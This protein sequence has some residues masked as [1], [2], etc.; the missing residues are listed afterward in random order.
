MADRTR[1]HSN[2][3]R[4]PRNRGMSLDD[5]L[6]HQETN[7]FSRKSQNVPSRPQFRSNLES[8]MYAKVDSDYSNEGISSADDI[9][10]DECE[11]ESDGGR[12][13]SHRHRLVEQRRR[14]LL[15][16]QSSHRRNQISSGL[17]EEDAVGMSAKEQE[18]LVTIQ[19]VQR[20]LSMI[21]VQ[22]EKSQ[23]EMVPS[24]KDSRR[25]LIMV[26]NRLPIS[27]TRDEV[28]GEWTFTM[29]SGGLVTA[30]NGIRDEVPFI[31][32]GWLGE[33][34]AQED[35]EQVREKL[36]NE[37]N[38]VPVFLPKELAARYYNDFSNDIL[39]PIFHYVP[40]PMFRPG[41]EKKF[42]FRPWEAYKLANKRFAQ[43]VHQ[44]YREGDFVWVHDYHLMM[45]PS[46]LRKRHPKATIAWFLHTPFPASDVYRMLP[47]GQ[48]ILR[49]LLGADLLGFHTY[50]YARHFLS[51]C[52]RIDGPCSTPKG[53]ELQDHFTAVGVYPIGIDPDHFQKLVD[54]EMTQQR[55]K[56]LCSR[57]AG[58]K[59]IIGVDRMDY[60]K[61]IPH[62]ML[63]M[64][65]FLTMYPK[66]RENVVLIQ[67]AVP[68]RTSVLEY[69]NLAANVNEMVGRINGRFSTIEHSPVH[70]I[71]RS[72]RPHELVA[73]YNVAD[74]CLVT[75]LRDGMNLVSHEYVM[76]QVRECSARREGPG[77]LVLSEFAGSAQSLSGAIR[78]NPWNTNDIAT[79]LDYAL[80]LL[81]KDREYR[82][83]NLLRYVKT[84]SASFWGKSFLTDLEYKVTRPISGTKLS[85]LPFEDIVKSYAQTS[86]RLILLNVDNILMGG[87]TPQRTTMTPPKPAGKR[88]L[89]A[90]CA[91]PQNTVFVFSAHVQSVL[92]SWVRD[93]R[94][95]IVAE[96]GYYCRFPKSGEWHTLP[97]EVDL[98]WKKVVRPI[99]QYF[100][101]R[102]PGSRIEIKDS[103]MIWHYGET[104]SIFG[105]MQA[106]DMLLNLEDVLCNLPLEVLPGPNRVIV[107]LQGIQ[108]IKVLEEVMKRCTHESTGGHHP[109]DFLLCIGDAD[110]ETLFTFFRKYHDTIANQGAATP[111][112]EKQSEGSMDTDRSDD[113]S[114]RTV[115]RLQSIDTNVFSN[116]AGIYT[117]HVG[118][119]KK[120]SAMFYFEGSND[121]ISLLR[122]LASGC[123]IASS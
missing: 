3:K 46:L 71:H 102:T 20:Q 79:A 91:D 98:S 1:R 77:V 9:S 6:C 105:P 62:R 28:T 81:P 109:L 103:S 27:F 36:A 116:Q 118:T 4:L 10:D 85:K 57:F 97:E 87:G 122:G 65:R 101:E 88:V 67:V 115:Q 33:E 107:R 63:S 53:I 110:D 59:I 24:L 14:S 113:S 58:K 16:S 21:Q 39:W 31:W 18:L 86:N 123:Q 12:I 72:V 89:E 66:Y 2:S 68:S 100:T 108:K 75:S 117:C 95:G 74:V 30:L 121:V 54:A 84:H 41:S 92:T 73:L 96:S 106:R 47:V 43:A 90:L 104:D 55:I 7:A 26:S 37:F 35:Q 45:L 99:M 80:N 19:E 112:T 29:S 69:Q 64:E 23:D 38:C 42:D 70:Y 61:G 93:P 114:T 5:D 56:E 111:H 32:I 34:V 120:S 22:T 60:I 119:V 49:G 40:L 82:H 83:M 48:P 51:A 52:S 8:E 76:C 13:G 15:H 78:V 94:V 44:V 50:D 25:R 17:H 11:Q